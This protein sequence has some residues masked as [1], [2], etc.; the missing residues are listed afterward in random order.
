MPRLSPGSEER[1]AG[2]QS[3]IPGQRTERAALTSLGN[4]D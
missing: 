3:A 4:G 1:T 2:S